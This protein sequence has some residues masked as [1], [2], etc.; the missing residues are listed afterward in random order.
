MMLPL[1]GQ[2]EQLRVRGQGPKIGRGPQ[3][4]RD[5][6]DRCRTA[7]AQFS[8]VT[9]GSWGVGEESR[10]DGGYNSGV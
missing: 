1:I 6:R 8:D 5:P 2:K 3:E 4:R 9:E 10:T 7:G